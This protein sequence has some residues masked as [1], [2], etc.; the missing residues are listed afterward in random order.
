MP[1]HKRRTGCKIK[2]PPGISWRVACSLLGIDRWGW[3]VSVNKDQ[4]RTWPKQMAVQEA[5]NAHILTSTP[6]LDFSSLPMFGLPRFDKSICLQSFEPSFTQLARL[7]VGNFSDGNLRVGKLLSIP[8][9]RV[10][11]H[12]ETYQF[13]YTASDKNW[14]QCWMDNKLLDT[15]DE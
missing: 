1:V 11:F 9:L 12:S 8:R 15:R 14:N 5:M 13:K 6:L 10:I 4:E 7:P 3:R 2:L